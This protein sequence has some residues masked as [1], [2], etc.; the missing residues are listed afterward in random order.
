MDQ[1]DLTDTDRLRRLYQRSVAGREEPG[2][3]C[4]SP[5]AIA[6]LIRREGSEEERLAALEHVMSCAACHREYEWLYAVDQAA[7]EAGGFAERRQV[8]WRRAPLALAASLV[9]AIGAGLLVQNRLRSGSETVRGEEGDIAL[10]APAATAQAAG[11]LT[12]VWRPVP[13][14]SGYVVE[15]QRQDGSIAFSDTTAD[16]TLTLDQPTRVLNEAEHRWW[17]RE[18]TE[19]SEPRSSGLRPLRLSGR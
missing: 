18:V 10:V 15:V 7:D 13:D 1:P 4:V 12:F 9:A 6:A 5:E 8:W 16:T 17:V 2:N 11:S 19:G 14:A 3:A